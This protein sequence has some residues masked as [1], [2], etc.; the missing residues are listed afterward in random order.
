MP[1]LKNVS[2]V[3]FK[4]FGKHVN[5]SSPNLEILKL[6]TVLLAA[7]QAL[8]YQLAATDVNIKI[9]TEVLFSCPPPPS[10]L[11]DALPS[12]PSQVVCNSPAG[13]LMLFSFTLAPHR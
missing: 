13:D 8:D 3:A 9:N 1:P 12:D 4:G 10:T 11:S 2:C 6:L 7:A 5:D